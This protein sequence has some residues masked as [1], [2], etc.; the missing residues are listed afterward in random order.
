VVPESKSYQFKLIGKDI[1]AR[2]R[3]NNEIVISAYFQQEAIDT[4]A[5]VV[6]LSNLT[7]SIEIEFF[8]VVK[9]QNR[10]LE[11]QWRETSSANV[12]MSNCLL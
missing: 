6:L 10:S 11:L 8:S 4:A 12:F 3:I 7:H 2:V 5:E 1:A 9:S